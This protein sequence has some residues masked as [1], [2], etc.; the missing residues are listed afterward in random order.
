MEVAA[1]G[2]PETV[3]QKLAEL[4]ERTKADEFIFTSDVYEHRDRLR[5]FEITA[6]LMADFSRKETV[7]VQ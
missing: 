3:R 5:S 1:V 2:G 7:L 4:R 6:S